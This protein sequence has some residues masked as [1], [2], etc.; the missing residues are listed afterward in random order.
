MVG[1]TVH[2]YQLLEKLG[3]GG[4]GDI[5]K[6][7]DSRLNR[8]V[9]VKVL[10]SAAT[11][12]PERRRRFVQE[13]QAASALNHPNIITIHDI[14]SEGDTEFMVMEYVAGK[15]LVDLIP[16]GGLRTPQVLKYTVQMAD[17]L[18]VAHTA[19]IVHRDLKPGNVM[20]TDAGLVKVLD[21]GLAKLT[22]RGPISTVSGPDDKTQT[23]A[24]A[25]LTVEG[26]IIGTV[27]YM[28]PEQAQGKK[29]DT[30]SDIFSFGVVLYEMVTGVRAF[31]GE[32][33]LS[34][35][36]AILRDDVRPI[37]ETS[38]DVPPQL[39]LVISRCLKKSPDDRWQTMKDVQMALAAL[40][41]ESDSGILYRARMS[42]IQPPQAVAAVAAQA[43]SKPVEKAPVAA[44]AAAG[45][46][47]GSK[48][49]PPA[50][51]ASILG[52]VVFLA[53][54]VGGGVWWS[55][56]R[57]QAE[58]APVAAVAISNPE[59]APEPAPAPEPTVDTA[60]PTPAV[61]LPDAT[62]T[63]DNIIEMVQAKVSANVIMSQIRASKTNFTLTPAELIRLT[64][65]GVS[66]N[67]I[68]QM[69]NPK[70]AVSVASNT[71]PSAGGSSGNKG[72]AAPQVQPPQQP[73]PQP[74]PQQT[75]PQ[76]APTPQTAPQPV[77][78]APP[79]Q[80]AP[81]AAPTTTVTLKDAT[82]FSIVLSEAVPD[83]IE[84]GHPL[85]FTVGQDV[86]AGD[87]VVIAK[88]AAVTGAIVD[89][90]GKKILGI[91]GGKMTLKLIQAEGVDG[92][93]INV[94]ALQARRAEGTVRQVEP[95]GKQKVKDITAPAGTEYI[96]YVD[97]DQIVAA[98]Q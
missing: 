21:F 44:G 73:A 29:V 22:D 18:Q 57:K 1:R 86:K 96:A 85:R 16:K 35:L 61:P 56:H 31:S 76:P 65:A 7:Q 55:K 72:Q 68:E 79:V 27:S 51:L 41:H 71:A 50:V 87:V 33:A 90:P 95:Q 14:I 32:S 54:I 70:H 6:A 37:A 48:K 40:K 3:A 97:G 36:S 94:R 63:N 45:A 24:A 78:Q 67:V 43:P 15:T 82:P 88:G 89:L 46:A 77:T 59:P 91:G 19:G 52:G 42:E 30:R 8:F 38:P 80:A 11:G 49:M 20:V 66:E 9:A 74:A 39:E 58:P 25:P 12:D 92:H 81:K 5:Y 47:A 62:L 69:R 53:V 26:S 4:M 84:E 13:A 34:T 17:A 10:T 98:H 23:I 93:K 64:K 60:A 28:S 75:A 2:H 83:K